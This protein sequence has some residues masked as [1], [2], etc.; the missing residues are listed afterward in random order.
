MLQELYGYVQRDHSRHSYERW[1]SDNP[2]SPIGQGAQEEGSEAEV[3]ISRLI[4]SWRFIMSTSI[5]YA[6]FAI[7][8]RLHN[9]KR[10]SSWVTW[11]A[12]LWSCLSG[13]LTFH[14]R[15]YAES[16]F[17]QIPDPS[18]LP[19]PF[20][21][22][23]QQEHKAMWYLHSWLTQADLRPGCGP[24]PCYYFLRGQ[25]KPGKPAQIL[26]LLAESNPLIS[27]HLTEMYHFNPPPPP[28]PFP[29][30]QVD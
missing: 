2:Q 13:T 4:M 28:H 24:S 9:P 27:P 14:T 30:W 1:A 11:C 3:S 29:Q 8:K 7:N 22:G 17:A 5:N 25:E 21:R 12:S 23:W 26:C 16:Y 20:E 15:R 19:V 6:S 10:Q 18:R